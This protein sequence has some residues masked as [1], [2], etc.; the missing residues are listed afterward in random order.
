[1][2]PQRR[3]GFT[4]VE[5][6]VVIGIISVLASL[7][8]PC[9]QKAFESART[10]KCL[11]NERQ[12]GVAMQLY[13][14]DSNDRLPTLGSWGPAAYFTSN[15]WQVHVSEY[16]GVTI[17]NGS[18]GVKG[19]IFECP[20]YKLTSN[21]WIGNCYANNIRMALK[22]NKSTFAKSS[23][24]KRP[25]KTCL[26]GDAGVY[27]GHYGISKYDKCTYSIRH[28][29]YMNICVLFVDGHTEPMPE[30]EFKNELIFFCYSE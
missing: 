5:L 20:N 29:N 1:M 12:I 2:Q 4:L 8:L 22:N 15:W 16:S 26:A 6:L 25:S 27:G 10:M 30:M 28:N 11:S 17:P 19:T 3:N 23:R 21:P 7:L 9:L 14:E 13:A 24:I 18:S